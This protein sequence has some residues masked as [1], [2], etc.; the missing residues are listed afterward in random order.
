[1]LS[2]G[3]LMETQ[4]VAK[5]SDETQGKFDQPHVKICKQ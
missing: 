2:F 1:M 3:D 5:R 4:F